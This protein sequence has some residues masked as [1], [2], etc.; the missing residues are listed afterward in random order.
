[1]FSRS[2]AFPVLEQQFNY[3]CSVSDPGC[4]LWQGSVPHIVNESLDLVLN[5]AVAFSFLV[6]NFLYHFYFPI[7]LLSPPFYRFRTPK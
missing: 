1:M 2:S 6:F 7:Y 3:C 4:Y 5:C